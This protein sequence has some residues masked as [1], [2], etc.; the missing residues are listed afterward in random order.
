MRNGRTSDVRPLSLGVRSFDQYRRQFMSLDLSPDTCPIT[1]LVCS[2]PERL[3]HYKSD[4]RYSLSPISSHP[5]GILQTSPRSRITRPSSHLSGPFFTHL[6]LDLP[7][8]PVHSDWNK[9]HETFGNLPSSLPLGLGWMWTFFVPHLSLEE[10]TK[11]FFTNLSFTHLHTQ[12]EREG[13]EGLYY[14]K[15]NSDYKKER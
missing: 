1:S 15:I 6:R 13:L 4:S 8:P 2:F 9:F 7:D 14:K 5:T 10:S 11:D 3:L 12:T